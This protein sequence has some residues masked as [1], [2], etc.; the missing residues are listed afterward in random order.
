MAVVSVLGDVNRPAVTLFECDIGYHMGEFAE[1]TQ[2]KRICLANGSWD[3]SEPECK[4]KCSKSQ[5][6]ASLS[7]IGMVLVVNC[8]ELETPTNGKKDGFH[9]SYGQTIRF[10]CNPGYHLVGTAIRTCQANGEWN[11]TSTTCKR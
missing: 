5:L 1:T 7:I 9:Y 8:K 3:G 4:G 10:K 6:F 2:S 11:G